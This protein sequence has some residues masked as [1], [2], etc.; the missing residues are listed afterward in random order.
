LG[1]ITGQDTELIKNFL[2]TYKKIKAV[3]VDLDK[4]ESPEK[5]AQNDF[6]QLN[7]ER[8]RLIE[9]ALE[10]LQDETVRKMIERRFISGSSRNE[11]V[12]YFELS[13]FTDRTIDRKIKQGI[14]LITESIKIWER[15]QCFERQESQAIV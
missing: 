13:G 2:L 4:N 11:A 14:K 6:Y 9:R 10:L 7:S 15:L 12:I 3:I 1:E 5:L 8:V